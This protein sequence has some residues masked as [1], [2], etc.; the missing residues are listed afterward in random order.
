[1]STT[2]PNVI[3]T[4]A[5]SV[6][7]RD[8]EEFIDHMRVERGFSVNTSEAYRRDLEHYVGWLVAAEI[9][10]TQQI[11]CAHVLRY[12]HDLRGGQANPSGGGR[13]YA[14]SSVAR[15]L[16]AVR[17]WHKFLARERGYLDPSSK[18]DGAKVPRKLPH[19]LSIEQVKDILASPVLGTPIGVRDRALLELLY[20]SGLRASELCALRAGD[21][22]VETGFI[23][24][25]GKGSKERVVP[26][27]QMAREAV[28]QYLSFARPK[29]LESRAAR[30]PRDGAG[31]AGSSA[32]QASMRLFLNEHGA[33]L[34]RESLYA[35]VRYHAERANLP[36]WVSPHTLRH[37]FATHLLQ[38]GADLRAIQEML[39]HADIATTQIYTHVETGHLRDSFR[40][41]H[42]R[43]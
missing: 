3:Q 34:S 31:G 23:R 29:L 14:A 41:A 21:M 6:L 28:E 27:G 38:G 39:G 24:T 17:S 16:A 15:K 11:E 1:M 20:A 35:V 18:L 2:A 43:A 26:L 30:K 10:N 8:V 9:S 19:A 37:S 33:A 22:N 4:G 5:R 12:A 25:F 7:E 13:G 36:D 42:P 40:K 32:R